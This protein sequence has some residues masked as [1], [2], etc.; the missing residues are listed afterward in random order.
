VR[1]KVD[2]YSCG[3]TLYQLVS[4]KSNGEI[5]QEIELKKTDRG[6]MMFLDEV[7]KLKLKDDHLGIMKSSLTRILFRVFQLDYT[8]RP[9]FKEYV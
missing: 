5:L 9:D 7:A 6:Y 2:V 3:M 1:S 8:R 4:R